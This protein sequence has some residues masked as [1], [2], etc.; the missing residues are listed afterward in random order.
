MKLFIYGVVVGLVF[1]AGSA[2]AR[3]GESRAECVGR[4][5]QPVETNDTEMV[6]HKNTLTINV[7]FDDAGKTIEL[8]FHG[9]PLENWKA[10]EELVRRNLGH[11]TEEKSGGSHRSWFAKDGSSYAHWMAGSLVIRNAEQ[12]PPPEGDR[13]LAHD[14][15]EH[16]KEHQKEIL[17]KLDGF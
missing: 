11:D 15:V 5:G 2:W 17:E 4:Y 10:G 8:R 16:W 12:S 13:K 6:F 3:L 7:K 14:D 1:G 9:A